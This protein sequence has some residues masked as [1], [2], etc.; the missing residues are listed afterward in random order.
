MKGVIKDPEPQ[1]FQIKSH[2]SCTKEA[3][4]RLAENIATAMLT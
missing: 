4:T 2:F 3:E 1:F